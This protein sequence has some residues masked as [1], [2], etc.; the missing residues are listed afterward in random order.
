MH[1]T[2]LAAAYVDRTTMSGHAGRG[3]WNPSGADVPPERFVDYLTLV[4]DTLK[5]WIA[6]WG[7]MR[8]GL[9]QE[10]VALVRQGLDERLLPD[11]LDLVFGV[12]ESV[13]ILAAVAALIEGFKF[14]VD[15]SQICFDVH[16]F[17]TYLFGALACAN[18][19]L[20]VKK[21]TPGRIARG[22]FPLQ[23]KN[24]RGA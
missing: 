10:V 6:V 19:S 15:I 21:T 17:V 18:P 3:T 16:C 23:G 13:D 14:L 20:L 22:D 11:P 9:T 7:A 24:N 2:L 12:R 4:G 8:L 1:A 5:G